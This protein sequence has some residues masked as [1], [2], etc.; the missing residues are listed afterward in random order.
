MKLHKGHVYLM[1]AF[2]LAGTSVVTGRSLTTALDSFAITIVSLGL[3]LLC[4]FPFFAA[5]TLHTIRRLQRTDWAA[6]LCQGLFGIFLFRTLLLTGL[7]LTSTAEAGILTGA[8]PAITALLAWFFLHESLSAKAIL[9]IL[10]TVT[11]IM[12]LQNNPLTNTGLLWQH[13]AGNLLVLGA[14]ACES[15]FNVLSRKQNRNDESAQPPIHPLVQTMLVAVIAGLLCLLPAIRGKSLAPIWS[16]GWQE[17]GALLWYG[18]II[19]ALSFVCFYEGVKRCDAYTTA[20][21]SGL[22]PLTALLLSVLLL[23]ES[24]T[25][26]QWLG[27]SLVVCSVLLLT[28][29]EKAAPS[30]ED[31]FT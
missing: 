7:P 29:Q 31:N 9:G 8:A 24:V 14:A 30:R 1:L 2:S 3:M 25:Y 15:V 19:T 6:L 5:K 13:T 12:L 27:S 23:G 28:N 17:W 20:A 18:L 22:L 26:R 16:I 10:C 4:L 11:G 21:L